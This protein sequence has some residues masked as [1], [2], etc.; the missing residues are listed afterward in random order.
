MRSNDRNALRSVI[1]KSL[2]NKQSEKIKTEI[3][4]NRNSSRNS[5]YFSRTSIAVRYGSY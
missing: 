4:I 2:K 3:S 5:N 1:V